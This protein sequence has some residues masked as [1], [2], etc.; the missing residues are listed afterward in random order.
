M[1]AYSFVQSEAALTFFNSWGWKKSRLHLMAYD[2]KPG[3]DP[4]AVAAERLQV[5]T[6]EKPSMGWWDRQF[7]VLHQHN[8]IWYK[9]NKNSLQKRLNIDSASWNHLV[10]SNGDH[11]SSRLQEVIDEKNLENQVRL[12][13]KE[14][15]LLEEKCKEIVNK[16]QGVWNMTIDIAAD[17]EWK[18]YIWENKVPNLKECV[19]NEQLPFFNRAVVQVNTD[20]ECHTL[21]YDQ[22]EVKLK[23]NVTRDDVRRLFGWWL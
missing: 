19:W 13:R 7:Y 6:G 15:D 5:A 20:K 16:I 17:G 23:K 10:S 9:I 1:Q 22:H 11:F 18:K 3:K 4:Y 21:F 8:N 12:Y 2:G 14:W